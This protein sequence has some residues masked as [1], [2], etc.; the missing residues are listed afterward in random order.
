MVLVHVFQQNYLG[1]D[2][3][4]SDCLSGAEHH[5]GWIRDIRHGQSDAL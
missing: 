3:W 2:L 4:K 5:L 1:R